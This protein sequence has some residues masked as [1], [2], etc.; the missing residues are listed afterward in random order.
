MSDYKN[1]IIFRYPG[2][3]KE[4]LPQIFT[5]TGLNHSTPLDE[6]YIKEKLH[7]IF[8]QSTISIE[9]V[10]VTIEVLKH[11]ATEKYEV[12]ISLVSSQIDFNIKQSG[13]DF[14]ELVHEVL[15]KTISFIHKEK[16]KHL[17]DKF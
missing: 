6:D 17:Q 11:S 16:T 13:Y 15:E 12:E 14:S 9:E 8:D 7:P 2:D 4:S 3:S 10:L 5:T 1:K